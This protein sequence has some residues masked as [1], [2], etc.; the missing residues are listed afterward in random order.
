MNCEIEVEEAE[1]ALEA[2]R[3]AVASVERADSAA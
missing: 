2:A 3:D 1:A